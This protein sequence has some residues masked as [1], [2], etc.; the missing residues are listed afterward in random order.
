M[1]ASIVVCQPSR[2]PRPCHPENL[3]KVCNIVTKDEPTVLC[4]VRLFLSYLCHKPYLI[5]G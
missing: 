1:E 5:W 2:P 4:A 3:P